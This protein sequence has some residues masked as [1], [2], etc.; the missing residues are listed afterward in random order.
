MLCYRV[1]IIDTRAATTQ[2][3][4]WMESEE[5]ESYRDCPSPFPAFHFGYKDAVVIF[6]SP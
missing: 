4:E 5:H 6:L 3:L 2:V 1:V